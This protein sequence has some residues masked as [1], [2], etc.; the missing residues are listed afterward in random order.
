MK[1]KLMLAAVIGL[2]STGA[3]FALG[4]RRNGNGNCCNQNTRRTRTSRNCGTCP[5]KRN[6]NTC[7]KRTACKKACSTFK[8][9]PVAPRCCKTIMV[10]KVIQVA[11]V[12]DVPARKI[13]IPQPDL[14]EYIPQQPV[15]IRIPQPPIPQP[16]CIEYRSVPDKVVRHPQEAC[17]RFECPDDCN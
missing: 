9:E 13:V 11:K 3:L 10:D 4:N 8:T 16:D 12:I 2:L 14:I 17:I 7:P 1:N 6:C 15:E 5:K